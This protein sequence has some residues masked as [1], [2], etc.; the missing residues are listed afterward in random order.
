MDYLKE[1][2][3]GPG[4]YYIILVIAVVII[5]P[6][7]V[8][9]FMKNKKR[10][11]E[12]FLRENPT[13]AKVY[14]KRSSTEF[15]IISVNDVPPTHFYKGMKTG[16]YI[17]PGENKINFQCSWTRAGVVHKTVTTT[18][19]PISVQVNAEANKEYQISYDRK[20]EK[21]EFTEL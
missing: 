12:E 13:A 2:L 7:F 14:V 19:G 17:V 10:K 20:A 11:A 8:V 16:F 18:V 1:L 6:I 3:S 5:Y 21:C 15:K 4:G 9:F